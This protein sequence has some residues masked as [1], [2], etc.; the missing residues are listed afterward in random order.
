MKKENLPNSA[1]VL[2]EWITTAEAAAY[3]MDSNLEL[4]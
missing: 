4:Y 1:N 2:C 3:L